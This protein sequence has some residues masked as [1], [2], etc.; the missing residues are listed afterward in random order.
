V[1]PTAS[2]VRGIDRD[3]VLHTL[4][5]E[6]WAAKF[7]SNKSDRE[8]L[9]RAGSCLSVRNTPTLVLARLGLRRT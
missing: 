2:Y 5:I 1:S 8:K 6:H 9:E 7:I 4:R 3:G